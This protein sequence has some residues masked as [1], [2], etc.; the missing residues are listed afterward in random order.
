LVTRQTELTLLQVA[1]ALTFHPAMKNRM[2][3]EIEGLKI[4]FI[5][6]ENLLKNKQTV[7]RAQNLADVSNLKPS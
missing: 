2:Q 4:D 5:N 7:G 3:I 1:K 6:Y